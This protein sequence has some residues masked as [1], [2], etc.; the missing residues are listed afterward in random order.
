MQHPMFEAV[1][2][3]LDRVIAVG[4]TIEFA[5][6]AVELISIEIRQAGALASW[7]A[8]PAN[9]LL[10]LDADVRVSDDAGKEY[11]SLAAGHEG[12]S[13]HWSGQSFFAPSPPVGTRI[14]LSILS[15]GPPIDHEVPR[16]LSRQHIHGPW[17][18][19]VET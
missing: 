4:R 5:G 14:T 17:E 16:G 1:L 2:S 15:F 9:D 13:V 6:V 11:A 7:R 10:L 8:K 12:S 3:P 19:T 18:F